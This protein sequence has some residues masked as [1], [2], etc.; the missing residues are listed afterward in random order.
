MIINYDFGFLHNTEVLFGEGKISILPEKVK[1]YGSKAIVVSDKG[2]A[3]TG[4]VERITGLLAEKG[5]DT[6][7]YDDVVANPR[8]VNCQE[9]ADMAKGFG[10]EVI[11]GVGGGSAMDTAKAVNVLMTHGGT[12]SHWAEVRKFDNPLLPLICVPT[13]SGTGSEVTFEAVITA[14]DLGRKVSM[15]D[16]N[17]LAPKAAIMDPELTLT[18]PPLVT[19]STG[20]DALTHAIEAY[21]CKF[22]QPISDSLAIYAIERIAGGIEA[23]TE[24]GGALDARRDMM[25][26]SLM[27]G[28]A[29]TNSYLG[30]V[31]SFSERL[32]GFYDIPHGIA[33]AIFLPF[34]TEFN[35][36]ADYEKHA[37]V[38]RAMGIDTGGMDDKEA[39]E[40][41]VSRLFEMNESLG[42]PKFS[43]LEMVDPEDFP[44]IADLCVTH[45]CGFKAN[46][47]DIGY[48]DYMNIFRKAYE[49]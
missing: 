1:Q 2:I 46:P 34:V 18:V 36:S 30:A 13:T 6:A 45:P 48:D 47:R 8:D 42:I 21:T 12:C 16:G 10:A 32:G 43:E 44:E 9:A 14:T 41:L 17:K 19:A 4:I 24:N 28:M 27:A 7:V 31:H 38:A 22:A 25:L 23:A 37:R 26:G 11:I 33:N 39:S 49:Y 20:M 3:K 35:I 29:F 15:S 40:A 5:V